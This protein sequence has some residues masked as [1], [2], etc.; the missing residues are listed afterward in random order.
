MSTLVSTRDLGEVTVNYSEAVLAGLAPDGGLY[1]PDS[2]PLLT[3]K[4]IVEMGA[5]G[6][7]ALATEVKGLFVDDAFTPDDVMGIMSRSYDSEKFPHTKEGI[8]TPARYLGDNIYAVNLSLGPTAAF[9]DMALQPL[10]Q[11][12]NHCLARTGQRLRIL[13]ATSGDTGSAAEAAVKGL[14]NVDIFMLSPVEGMSD[15]QKAQMGDLSGGNVVNISVEGRFDDCQDL[16]KLLK[17][18]PEFADLGAV[19]SINWSRISSQVAYYFS[20]YAQVAEHYGDPV[21][22]VVPSGNFG[23]ILA[24]YIAKKMGLP[25]RNL[26]AATNENSVLDELVQTGNYRT[27]PADITSSPSMDISKASNFERVAYDLFGQDPELLAHYMRLFEA[28]GSV[29]FSEVGLPNDLL[30][31]AGFI[32]GIS[33]HKDRVA[34]IRWAHDLSRTVIDPHT[35]DAVTVARRLPKDGVPKVCLETALAVKFPEITEEAIGDVP[36]REPRFEALEDRVKAGAFTTILP[37]AD[38]LKELIRSRS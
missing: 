10:G 24:G 23:N 26:V 38:V 13:G 21:D 27:R 19:N 31:R 5:L 25:I 28:E 35:A 37:D 36:A 29:K 34:S 9:K 8:V 1:V 33:T 11:E 6:F 30:L 2:Y 32:S 4:E 18:D 16:V 15:F 17:S 7:V 14:D 3:D 22:F 20:A 12:M